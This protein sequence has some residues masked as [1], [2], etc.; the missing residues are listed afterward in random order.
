MQNSRRLF[1]VVQRHSIKQ[2]QRG[3]LRLFCNKADNSFEEAFVD[4]EQSD[5]EPFSEEMA[6][7]MNLLP[8]NE[9]DAVRVLQTFLAQMEGVQRLQDFKSKRKLSRDWSAEDFNNGER[10]N[11]LILAQFEAEFN[12]LLL[13]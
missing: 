12:E 2:L 5:E 6:D 9:E 7:F 8:E 13:T 1:N 10:E 4:E 3:T 11:A